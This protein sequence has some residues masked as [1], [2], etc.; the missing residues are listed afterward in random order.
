MDF[1]DYPYN[2]VHSI[3]IHSEHPDTVFAG[4]D[5]GI[6]K[7]I[8]G[9]NTWEYTELNDK[10]V[11]MK[12]L[13]IDPYNPDH[14]WA[15]GTLKGL[16]WMWESVDS[17]AQWNSIDPEV[18]STVPGI[19]NF[20]ADP[21]RQGV[22][23]IGSLGAGVWRYESTEQ[24]ATNYFPLQPGNRWTF[25]DV[26]SESIIDTM[27]IADHLY[28]VFDNFRH[29]P[30]VS[31]RMTDDNK[32]LLR[33]NAGEQIWLDFSAAVGD[34]WIVTEPG[35]DLKWKVHLQSK[36]DTVTVHAG[37]FTNCYRFW[38]DFGCCDND[39]VEWYAPNVG[40]VKRILYGFAVIE[41][42]LSSV[43]LNGEEFPTL[44]TNQP[45]VYI[46]EKVYLYP[47]YPNPFNAMTTIRYNSYAA[48]YIS[49]EIYNIMGKKVRTLVADYKPAGSYHEIWDGMDNLGKEVSSGTYFIRLSNG[50]NITV[51][52]MAYI[53]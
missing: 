44:V 30:D 34:T 23:Y 3:A 32:L 37:T 51:N 40:P 19:S 10:S 35:G 17:G 12:G 41:Y 43:V 53:R 18:T 38:F 9:G 14:L 13:T 31:L 27:R 6:I 25:S 4:L 50:A 47:N 1:D 39:W 42:P 26:Q 22:V 15:G 2:A 52:K 5:R 20:V 28:Y 46:P 16:L 21:Y 8:D 24:Q 29:Y 45:K 48:G 11:H 49:M 33:D 7:T 36:T